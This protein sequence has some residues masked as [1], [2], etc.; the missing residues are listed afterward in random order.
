MKNLK[1]KYLH[2]DLASEGSK[3]PDSSLR[4][5]TYEEKSVNGNTVARLH[6]TDSEGA[7]SL[8]K[9]IGRYITVGFTKCDE[10]CEKDRVSLIE[11]VSNEIRTLAKSMCPDGISGILVA[12]LGNRSIT[13][14]SLGP[15]CTDNINITRHLNL[16]ESDKKYLPEISA[17]APGVLA[18]TGIETVELI[19]GAAQSCQPSLIIVIDALAS[20]S[21][22]RLASTVQLSDTGISP[23]SG[24]GNHRKT[25]NSE[26]VGFPV[27]AIGVP[28]VVDSATLVLDAL[29]RAGI[30]EY[31][32]SLIPVLEEGM[33]FFVTLKDSDIAVS[34]LS[35]IL[36]E[37]LNLFFSSIG[38][39]SGIKGDCE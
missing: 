19:R 39:A 32:D 16:S 11:T 6:I 29:E 23:G 8:G 10:L 37:A 4:G 5:A 24:I 3:F 1:D 36:F 21:V 17:I 2:T 9:P 12:G 22:G 25:I 20:R 13:S 33:S 27:M 35:S 14:D 26:T 28:T 34:E 15:I 31:P 30:E 38:N 7:E 18:Q